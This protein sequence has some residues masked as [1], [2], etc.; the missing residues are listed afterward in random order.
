MEFDE[1]L[2]ATSNAYIKGATDFMEYAKK[3]HR[4]VSIYEYELEEI[5]IKFL[6]QFDTIK[7]IK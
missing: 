4:G 7:E 2:Y 6:E 5:L 1:Y 3:H